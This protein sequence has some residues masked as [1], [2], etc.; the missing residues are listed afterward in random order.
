MVFID[1]ISM[2]ATVIGVDEHG[3]YVDQIC[4]VCLGNLLFDI[5]PCLALEVMGGDLLFRAL[6]G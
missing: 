2:T 3:P 1:E 4:L 5:D 6:F